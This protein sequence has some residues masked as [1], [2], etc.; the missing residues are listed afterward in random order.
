[1]VGEY[2]IRIIIE[3]NGSVLIYVDKSH[4]NAADEFF[5]CEIGVAVIAVLIPFPNLHFS[6]SVRHLFG[7]VLPEPPVPLGGFL[8]YLVEDLQR[9]I[10]R[11]AVWAVCLQI[12]E[13]F[14]AKPVYFAFI[15]IVFFWVLQ[16]ELA[17]WVVYDERSGLLRNSP[18]ISILSSYVWADMCII[19]LHGFQ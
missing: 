16:R 1:M 3:S 10:C 19:V 9:C 18:D 7:G 15:A 4:G 11:V 14:C 8:R 13:Y 12:Y 17:K 5:F 2:P 6:I